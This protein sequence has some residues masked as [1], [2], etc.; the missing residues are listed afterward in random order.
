MKHIKFNELSLGY[1]GFKDIKIIGQNF[2]G[3]K[4]WDGY[5]KTPRP[6]NGL[7]FILEDIEFVFKCVD[8]TVFIAKKGDVVFV[9]K[10]C[11]YKVYFHRGKTLKSLDSYTVNFLV[12]DDKNEEVIIDTSLSIV[13]QN[14]LQ[15]FMDKLKGLHIVYS[16]VKCS[17]LLITS[18]FTALLDKVISTHEIN[19]SAY[20]P[21]R[22]GVKAL[23]YEWQ[24]NI[25]IG[26]YAKICSMSESSFRAYFKAWSGMSPVQYR[27]HIRIQTAKS[28][29]KE[30]NNPYINIE[31]LAEMTGFEDQFYFSRV[32][33]KV[34]GKSPR[35]YKKEEN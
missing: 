28:I 33:K 21:I 7:V 23:Q 19:S 5:M 12:F 29:I 18:R 10:G 17:K 31:Q 14:Q 6:D 1:Y 24:Q 25:P 27:N 15:H 35:D 20:Y 26:V 16:G 30:T 13:S 22:R 9:P 2:S 34:T 3:Y 11:I 8:N 4:E 32:F